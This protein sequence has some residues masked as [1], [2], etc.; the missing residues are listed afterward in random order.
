MRF[1]EGF[2]TNKKCDPQHGPSV[3]SCLLRIPGSY[4]SKCIGT[5]GNNGEVKV[6]QEWNEEYPAINYILREFRKFLINESIRTKV[7]QERRRS[8][9]TKGNRSSQSFANANESRIWWIEKLLWNPLPDHRKYVI[10]RILA[11]YLINIRKTS[12]SEAFQIIVE[13]LDKCNSLRR[14]DFTRNYLVKYNVKSARKSGYL[15]ISFDNLKDTNRGLTIY[16]HL[17]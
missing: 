12:E 10:W 2:L 7:I 16:S 15:P 5:S 8:M 14:L 6:I 13:W 17:T 1:A 4:N 11:P 3:N 9:Q